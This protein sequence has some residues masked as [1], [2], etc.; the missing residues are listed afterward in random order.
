MYVH[1]LFGVYVVF[2]REKERKQGTLCL[3]QLGIPC[4]F[5]MKEIILFVTN[6][7]DENEG[8]KFKAF[9]LEI[10]TLS[11]MIDICREVR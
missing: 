11:V 4:M 2:E 10:L 7:L 5:S 8:T 3:H 9:K 1:V 6:F